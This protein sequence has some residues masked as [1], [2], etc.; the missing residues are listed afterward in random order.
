VCEQTTTWGSDKSFRAGQSTASFGNFVGACHSPCSYITN[1]TSCNAN[2]TW[3]RW[4]AVTLPGLTS[5][6]RYAC[7][8][9]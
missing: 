6:A 1:Q 8:G 2:S 3:C 7:R 9:K 4:K 5:S